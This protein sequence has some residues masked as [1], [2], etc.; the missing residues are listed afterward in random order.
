MHLRQGFST[1]VCAARGVRRARPARV[2]TVALA[3][4][5]ATVA[6]LVTAGAA[7]AVSCGST[8]VTVTSLHGTR[9][10][11]DA[12]ASPALS[13]GYTGYTITSSSARSNVWVELSGF[14]GVLGLNSNQPS[15]APIGNLGAGA[16]VPSYFFLTATSLATTAT[17][18]NFTFTLYQGD[19][20]RGGTTIC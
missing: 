3:A 12:A 6:A 18:Q 5:A 1:V 20:A 16:T 11:T 10:Y 14:S 9:F 4:A 7:L 19:P 17:P 15:A 8:G 2:L 13:S